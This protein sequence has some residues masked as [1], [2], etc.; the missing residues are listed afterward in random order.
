MSSLELL[1]S[2]V[3]R[4][5]GQLDVKVAMGG[6]SVVVGG[7]GTGS[8]VGGGGAVEIAPTFNRRFGEY[9][10]KPE[11][12]RRVAAASNA[13]PTWAGVAPGFDCRYSA[14]ARRMR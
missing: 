7:G 6:W 3:Q 2:N 11:M 4:P 10:S 9:L 12:A 14:S 1:A 13:S 8:V 5:F